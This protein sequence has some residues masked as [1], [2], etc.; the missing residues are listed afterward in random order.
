MPESIIE[1]SLVA[2]RKMPR[3]RQDYTSIEL[4]R[5][6]VPRTLQ[7][8][9]CMDS[10]DSDL[11]KYIR[12]LDGTFTRGVERIFLSPNYLKFF[13]QISSTII[14]D[15]ARTRAII[16]AINLSLGLSRGNLNWSAVVSLELKLPPIRDFLIT[17]ALTKDTLLCLL[18]RE[19]LQ[20]EMALK[21]KNAG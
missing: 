14:A 7:V 8:G 10:F 13:M 5:G 21:W 20:C 12:E 3:T 6:A 2:A 1:L 15:A 11:K 4:K 16:A 19:Y 18:N 17:Y 9:V